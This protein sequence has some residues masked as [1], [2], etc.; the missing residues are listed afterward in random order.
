MKGIKLLRQ[1]RKLKRKA[2]CIKYREMFDEARKAKRMF[3]DPINK[4]TYLR[5]IY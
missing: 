1:R 3:V 5:I 4:H 2:K